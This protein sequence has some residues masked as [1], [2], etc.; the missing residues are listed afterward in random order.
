ME[1]LVRLT[2]AHEYTRTMVSCPYLWRIREATAPT[3]STRQSKDL[4]ESLDD[5]LALLDKLH[6]Y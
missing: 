6:I 4:F 2:K 1:V 3:T 5:P